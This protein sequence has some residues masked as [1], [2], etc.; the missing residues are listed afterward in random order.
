MSLWVHPV[1]VIAL[2]AALGLLPSGPASSES[3]CDP[4]LESKPGATTYRMRGDRCEGIFAQQVS[5]P[6][7]EIRS[8]V[9]VF[10]PF[11]PAKDSELVLAWKTPPGDPNSVQLRAFSFKA[12]TY[13]RMDTKVASPGGTYHWP[14][15]LLGSLGLGRE[16]LGLLAWTE[17]PGPDG[18]KRKVY[19]PLRVGTGSPKGEAGYTVKF[20]PSTRLSEVS[21]KVS[22][23]D[24]QGKASAVVRDDKLIDEYFPTGEPT[25]FS[26]G[27]LGPAGFYRVT[28]TA[29]PKTR[30]SII[31]DFDLY[32]PGD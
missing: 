19:L 2:L 7:I 5:S 13:Y 32:H 20:L 21:V 4:G 22:R 26:T 27:K 18:A 25:A 28:I 16:D 9:S 12:A 11:D 8:L 17:L 23:L 30:L 15:D 24:G 31:Q 14:A 6:H 29:I 1:P 10:D 3:F